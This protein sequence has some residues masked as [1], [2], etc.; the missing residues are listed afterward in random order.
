MGFQDG[1]NSALGSLQYIQEQGDAGK[2]RRE[3][4][5]LA[6]L[7][8]QVAQGGQPDYQGIAANGGDPLAFRNDQQSQ[9]GE[10]LKQVG[11]FAQYFGTLPPEAKPAAYQQMAQLLQQAG[12]PPPPPY[13][14]A[15]EE[16]IAK[17]AQMFGSNQQSIAPRVIGNSLVDPTG[18]VL[19]QG[20]GGGHSRPVMVP[21]GQGGQ[22]MKLFDPETRQ[23]SDPNFSGQ[24]QAPSNVQ[25][26]FAPG[27]S[28]AVMDATR[29]AAAADQGQGGVTM[30]P[31]QASAAVGPRMGYKPPPAPKSPKS[32]KAS[33]DPAP[34]NQDALDTFTA[35]YVMH[36][37]LPAMGMGNTSGRTEVAANVAKI[38]RTLHLTPG[39]LLAKSADYK[40]GALSLANI[41]KQS[42]MLERNEQ[43]FL[44][45]AD[46][47]LHLSDSV[48]RSGLPAFNQFLLHV[49]TNYEGDPNAAAFLAS[50]N[51]VAQ[52]YAKIA[53]GA[54][55]AAGSS[56]TAQQHALDLINTAQTPQQLRKVIDTLRTDADQQKAA[57]KSQADAIRARL[58]G[59]GKSTSAPPKYTV[60][61]IIEHGGK[62]Y[63]V[64]GGDPNDPNVEPI[65]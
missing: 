61:Q 15:H 55:G 17:L 12:F 30:P 7:A 18:K 59:I 11:Q 21:D 4:S 48:S 46:T 58:D 19:F 13:D 3:K 31:Q 37:K 5:S 43:S 44:S 64:T 60:G 35:D 26:D 57:N 47:M 29:A 34:T 8:A 41:Q 6:Q 25:F 51:I 2:A 9:R 49:K 27:T 33:A 36:G 63:R 54:T 39:E 32:A 38:A 22:V 1:F 10:K 52:E 28:Q 62:R 56:D 65:P 50:R 20:Q 40:A 16:P 45:N 14:P 53:S 24:P 23:F 42:D